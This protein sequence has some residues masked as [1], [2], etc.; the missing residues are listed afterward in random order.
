MDQRLPVCLSPSSP[1]SLSETT[2][3]EG[4]RNVQKVTMTRKVVGDELNNEGVDTAKR[5]SP[6][7]SKKKKPTDTVTCSGTPEGEENSLTKLPEEVITIGDDD[8]EEPPTVQDSLVLVSG[9]R[10]SS[11]KQDLMK[12]F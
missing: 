2:S 1:V 3:P 11:T 7:S 9:L 6:D 10:S 4:R 8:E 12:A 5:H